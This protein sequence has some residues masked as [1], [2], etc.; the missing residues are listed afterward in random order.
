MK[1]NTHMA[2]AVFFKELFICSPFLDDF[3]LSFRAEPLNV[4]ARGYNIII[5]RFGALLVGGRFLLMAGCVPLNVTGRPIKWDEAFLLMWNE[6]MSD[7][8][9]RGI[10]EQ[11]CRQVNDLAEYCQ[12]RGQ[13]VLDGA[14]ADA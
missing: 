4:F 11:Q 13:L 9:A 12:G 3:R 10:R 14:F 2:L 1:W 7:L 8:P 6:A 5:V